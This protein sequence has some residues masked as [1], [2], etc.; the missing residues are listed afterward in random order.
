M[1]TATTFDPRVEP[2]QYVL[3]V[4]PNY[5]P[6]CD[7]CGTPS[8]YARCVISVD[9]A[10]NF[11]CQQHYDELC[12]A[13]QVMQPSTDDVL[14]GWT[15]CGRGFRCEHP[16]CVHNGGSVAT[17]QNPNPVDN[18]YR[19]EGIC[20]AYVCDQHVPLREGS[21]F[22]RPPEPPLIEYPFWLDRDFDLTRLRWLRGTNVVR[23]ET[24]SAKQIP[25]ARLK[26]LLPL[27]KAVGY[28]IEVTNGGMTIK[29]RRAVLNEQEVISRRQAREMFQRA[30]E[31][32]HYVQ[33]AVQQAEIRWNAL[34]H[35]RAM[36]VSPSL[37]LALA[38]DVST[39]PEVIT[40]LAGP[41]KLTLEDG[42]D[43][44][45]FEN[46][47]L[48][49]FWPTFYDGTYS[50][51]VAGLT[52][53]LTFIVD[54]NGGVRTAEANQF[55]PHSYSYGTICAGNAQFFNGIA[56]SLGQLRNWV[57]STDGGPATHNWA[58]Q[59]SEWWESYGSSFFAAHPEAKYLTAAY[60][61][62]QDT[63]ILG[64]D[65]NT[66][67]DLLQT[68]DVDTEDEEDYG[69][70]TQCGTRL[71]AD[72][73]GHICAHCGAFVCCAHFDHDFDMCLD[74]T[75]HMCDQC[76]TVVSRGRDDERL[77]CSSCGEYLCPDCFGSNDNGD[78][79]GCQP[80]E[81]EEEDDEAP[82]EERSN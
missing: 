70:C 61:E 71:R 18:H 14:E 65:Q 16:N 54:L 62:S 47:L 7:L 21:T 36:P 11:M 82:T 46:E 8:S 80:D 24:S 39:W 56:Q 52:A 74:C 19:M 53:P 30:K 38:S 12:S 22:V 2:D 67:S 73:E 20:L 77:F 69:N 66:L 48:I 13:T 79:D 55:H 17:W 81:T 15:R 40:A 28:G 49:R 76:E 10:P 25:M 27:F 50:R 59:A 41:V 78:C 64:L 75:P 34:K 23:V 44:K 43:A 51:P 29:R 45:A 58:S 26:V 33:D 32:L 57:V 5:R 68:N 6:T 63:Q 72:D 42:T 31:Q 35:V 37:V 9:W 1:T 3:Q 60:R 4:L